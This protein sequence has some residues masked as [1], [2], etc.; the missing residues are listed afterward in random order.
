MTEQSAPRWSSWAMRRALAAGTPV[1]QPSWGVGDA[2]RT[3]GLA[4]AATIALIVV[5]ARNHIDSGNGWGLIATS[6]TTWAVMLLW[7]LRVSARKGNGAVLDYGLRV[8]PRH[9]RLAAIFFAVGFAAAA[10]AAWVITKIHGDFTSAA[11]QAASRQ[12]GAVLV[13]FALSSI[14]I[15]PVCEEMV[16]RG[17]LFTA[18]M[19]RGMSDAASVGGSAMLFALFHLEP[20]RL[21]LLLV[22]GVVLGEVRRRTGSTSASMVTHALINLLPA[23]SML[24]GALTLSR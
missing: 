22:L 14:I 23:L 5:L 4:L 2:L 15:A 3:L 18:L 24:S 10:A 8:S 20:T 19:K 16:F 9:V 12:H 17:L 1:R 13:T 11:G 6:W 21:P 7:P